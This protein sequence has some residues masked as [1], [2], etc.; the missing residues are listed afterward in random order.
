MTRPQNL[1]AYGAPDAAALA[2]AYGFGIAKTH[3][4]TDGHKRTA[5]VAARL[6]LR[7][8]GVHLTF[9]AASAVALMEGVA[10]NAVSEEELA[11]WFRA[12]IGAA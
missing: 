6:F 10:G 4:F 11:S 12:R 3:G 8:N 7:L 5:W 9:D 1:A 2:A